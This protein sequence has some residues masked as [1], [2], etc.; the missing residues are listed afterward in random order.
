MAKPRYSPRGRTVL[1]TGAARGIG[2]DAARRLASRGAHVSLVGLEPDQLARIARECG[3]DTVWFECDVT[4]P[5]SL[6]AAVAGT[7]ERT[8]GID[9][10]VANA[11]IA[12]GDPVV[13]IDPAVFERVIEVNLLGAWRTI[14]AAL[15][16]VIERKGYLLPVAS[17][18]AVTPAFLGISAYS[19][20]KA[21]VEAFARTLSVELDPLGVDVG[22]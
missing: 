16:Y 13:A 5:A 21:G 3:A 10:V 1:I 9:V 18:A 14:R 8:G 12:A 15:P 4:D 6:D 11:G 2:A 7:V 20:S 22:V 19:A 17:L